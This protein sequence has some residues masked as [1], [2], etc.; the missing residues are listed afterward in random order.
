MTWMGKIENM[1][2]FNISIVGAIYLHISLVYSNFK[3][4]VHNLRR[5]FQKV[6]VFE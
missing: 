5:I 6:K 2:D 4:D 1:Q 3:L